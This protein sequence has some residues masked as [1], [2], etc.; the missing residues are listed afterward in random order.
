M[1]TFIFIV[2]LIIGL[3]WKLNSMQSSPIQPEVRIYTSEIQTKS[4]YE[5]SLRV[6]LAGTHLATRKN[7]I[8]KN[9]WDT[10]PVDLVPEPKNKFDSDAIAVKHEEK[11]IGYIPQDKTHLI[12]P[13]LEKEYEAAFESMEEEESY[14]KL[15]EIHL[16]VYLRINYN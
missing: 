10:M 15:G 4:K 3:I 9:G 14:S 12:H 16:T 7:Y 6:Y 11:L 2:L 8:L 5:N 1:G 13:I